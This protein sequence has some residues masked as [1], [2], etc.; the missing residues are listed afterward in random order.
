MNYDSRDIIYKE[1][2]YK[3]QG[4]IFDVY[5]EIG[6]GFLESVY[7]ECLQIELTERGIPFETQ[8]GINIWYKGR[9]LDGFYK[10][11]FICYDK[12]ILEIK[13]TTKNPPE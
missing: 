5:K 8:K 3:I 9:I 1:E 7:Q 10:P 12:I 6:L 13:S 4:A 2:C 11:D